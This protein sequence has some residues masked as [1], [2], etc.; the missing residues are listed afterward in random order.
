MERLGA[1]IMLQRRFLPYLGLMIVMVSVP[2]LAA[3]KARELSEK[4]KIDALIR[5]VSGLK[6]ARF[7]RKEA[8]LDCPSAA[9]FLR[10][11]AIYK[12]DEIVTARDFIR[13]CSAAP[14]G[15]KYVFR[16]DTGAAVPADAFFSFQLGLLT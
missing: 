7:I 4:Q 2:A 12:S 9:E 15:E 6:N 1:R 11:K 3:E 14:D 16:F 10:A 13:V 8:T 5:A